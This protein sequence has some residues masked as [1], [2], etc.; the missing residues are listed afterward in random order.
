MSGE[1]RSVGARLSVEWGVAAVVGFGAVVAGSRVVAVAGEDE[2]RQW[3]LVAGV[4]LAYQLWFLRRRLPRNR[5][6]DGPVRTS[7]GPANALT[8][9]RGAL[10]AAAGGFVVVPPTSGVRWLPGL[11]YG[12]GVALDYLDGWVARRTDRS[13]ALGADL[14]LAFDALG[15]LLVPPVGVVWGVLPPWYL[16]R[17]GE[18]YRRYRGRRVAP[19]PPS[20]VRRPLAALQMVV[21]TVALLPPFPPRVTIPLATASMVPSLVVFAR[22]WLVVSGR[23]KG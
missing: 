13:S 16:F 14:D 6:E 11:C 8:M 22:D 10:F 15:F 23:I 21:V 17:G 12:A 19:V 1:S 3:L 5:A 20:R 4:V 18:A 7:L 9:L 2:A